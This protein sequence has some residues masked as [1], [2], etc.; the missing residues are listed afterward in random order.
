MIIPLIIC[1]N[2]S[3]KTTFRS[4]IN[5]TSKDRLNTLGFALFIKFNYAIHNAVISYCK[6]IKAKL[7]CTT[8]KVRNLSKAIQQAVYGMYV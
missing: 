5:L 2:L 4:H 7:L 3:V 8:Y 1:S 6:T